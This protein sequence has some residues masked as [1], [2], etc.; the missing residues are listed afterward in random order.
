MAFEIAEPLQPFMVRVARSFAPSRPRRVR[1]SPRRPPARSSS[2]SDLIARELTRPRTFPSSIPPLAPSQGRKERRRSSAGKMFI[3]DHLNLRDD[4]DVAKLMAKHGEPPFVMFSESVLKINRRGE[5]VPRSMLVC[6][7][8][9]YLLDADT[10]RV[11]RKLP[12][13]ELGAIRMSELSDNFIALTYPAEYDVLLVCARK[14]EAVVAIQDAR[15]GGGGVDGVGG[16]VGA[17]GA[18]PAEIPVEIGM[19]FTY[20]AGADVLKRV[21]FE[22]LEDGDVDT[23]IEDEPR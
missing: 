14:I 8:S 11:R 10:R 3:G 18:P 13:R 17:G 5:A 22:R 2:S 7:R 23:T 4:P 16:V 9:V 19:S 6:A 15:A 21:R 12:I 20:R 1:G